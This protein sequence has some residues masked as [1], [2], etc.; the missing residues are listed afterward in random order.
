M[1]EVG[2][3]ALGHPPAA[4]EAGPEGAAATDLSLLVDALVDA[5]AS[6]G[7]PSSPVPGWS[8]S[9][10]SSSSPG[11]R[12]RPASQTP[13]ASPAPV[14]RRTGRGARRCRRWCSG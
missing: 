13:R 6:P 7:S 8:H 5:A 9:P 1:T 4:P 3:R 2:W 12:T 14:R 11:S 10:A